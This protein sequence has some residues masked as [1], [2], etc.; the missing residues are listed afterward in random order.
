MFAEGEYS[1]VLGRRRNKWELQFE[2]NATI[3]LNANPIVRQASIQEI[4]K[5][6]SSGAQVIS[7][8]TVDVRVENGVEVLKFN[9]RERLF[10]GEYI[11]QDDDSVLTLRKY[12][13]FEFES[14]FVGIFKKSDIEER[15][16][17]AAVLIPGVA[18]YHGTVYDGETSRAA[19]YYFM[20]NYLSDNHHGINIMHKGKL[21]EKAIR[22]LQSYVLDKKTT[23]KVNVSK[24]E[25]DHKSRDRDKVTYP[26]DTWVMW[27]RILD[28][29]IWEGVKKGT[30]TGWSPEGLGK[31]KPL[32][33]K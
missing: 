15:I 29:G 4:F 6:R 13:E 28:D 12:A 21:I 19:A 32:D 30:F 20:E 27:A 33:Q 8:G 24:T 2:R 10:D 11:V 5:T 3:I 23:Y 31:L 9:S 14:P 16:V 1:F 26:K 22:V 7:R 17:A 18:D 25:S